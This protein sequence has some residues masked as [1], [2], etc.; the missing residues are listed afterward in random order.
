MDVAAQGFDQQL[1]VE[2][3]VQQQAYAQ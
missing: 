3:H 1:I 2:R